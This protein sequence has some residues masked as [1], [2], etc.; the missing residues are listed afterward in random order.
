MSVAEPAGERIDVVVGI[1]VA[2]SRTRRVKQILAVD[3]CDGSNG[4]SS[5]PNRV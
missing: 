1:G 5:W 3:K 4:L 2:E